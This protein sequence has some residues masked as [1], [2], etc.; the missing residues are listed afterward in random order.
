MND[1]AKEKIVFALSLLATLFTIQPVLD[2]VKT[3]GFDMFHLRISLQHLYYA[4]AVLL[5]MSVY[6]YALNFITDRFFLLAQKIGNFFY[7]LSLVLPPLYFLLWGIL[8]LIA[9]VVPAFK[10]TVFAVI[11]QSLFGAI[12]GVAANLIS[13]LVAKRLSRRDRQSKANALT[14]DEA[15]HVQRAHQML[16]AGHFDLSVL[17]SYRAVEAALKRLLVEKQISVPLRGPLDIANWAKKKELLPAPAHQ[18]LDLLR[19]YRNDAVHTETPVSRDR[20]ETAFQTAKSLLS[21]LDRAES[22][23]TDEEIPEDTTL[24]YNMV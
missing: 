11:A 14:S 23:T 5:S 3:A 6:C 15:N 24:P 22:K 13:A 10:T 17:E 20:A 8:N 2:A 1:S 19:R 18:E 16:E 12:V 21:M 4:V 7:A 9:L